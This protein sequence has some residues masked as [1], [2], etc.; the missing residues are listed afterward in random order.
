MS[1]AIAL[2]VIEGPRSAAARA[3]S[4]AGADLAPRRHGASRRSHLRLVPGG[5][6][7]TSGPAAELVSAPVRLTRFG[8]LMLLALVVVAAGAVALV[9]SLTSGSAGASVTTP[10]HSITV[11]GGETLSQIAARELP[12]LTVTQGVA[13][14][15]SANSLPSTEVAAGQQLQIPAAG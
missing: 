4:L 11:A 13:R 10:A 3:E 15:Q 9:L 2:D 6:A 8:R 14:I 5:L 12:Q 1:A 7:A